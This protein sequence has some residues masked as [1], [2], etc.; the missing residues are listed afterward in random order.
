MELSELS[1]E[2]LLE[3]HQ[4]YKQMLEKNK[5]LESVKVSNYDTKFGYHLVRLVLQAEQIL[6]E[7]DLDLERNREVMKSIRRGEWELERL[8]EY[9][10]TKE[11]SLEETYAK[12]TLR[13]YPDEAAIKTLLVKCLEHHYGSLDKLVATPTKSGDLVR[14]LETLIAKYR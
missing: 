9:F 11:K 13:E 8:K 3:Y 12:S 7:H 5:R 6:N 4:L 10:V 2:E 14:E 1:D